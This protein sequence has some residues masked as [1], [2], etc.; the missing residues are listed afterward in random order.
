MQLQFMLPGD[1]TATA[2]GE[3]RRGEMELASL[4][5]RASGQVLDVPVEIGL[6]ADGFRSSGGSVSSSGRG[7][8]ASEAIEVD[9]W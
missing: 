9:A 7:D 5:V 2:T 4:Q 3:S 1:A 6:G 8:E